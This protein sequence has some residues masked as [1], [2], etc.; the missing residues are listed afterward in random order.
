MTRS[1]TRLPIFISHLLNSDTTLRTPP[2]PC[3]NPATNPHKP[4]HHVT[5]N[6]YFNNI[7]I[8]KPGSHHIYLTKRT[9]I[10]IP[11]P[12]FYCWHWTAHIISRGFLFFIYRISYFICCVVLLCAAAITYVLP[13][14][15]PDNLF[16][17]VN[18]L[19]PCGGSQPKL[20]YYN[21]TWHIHYFP[22]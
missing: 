1:V 5:S 8:N 15:H 10:Y 20:T 6:N 12:D 11:V 14:T 4:H 2:D 17:P 19:S 3:I 21:L 13:T 9:A 22:S 18:G 16:L 7:L